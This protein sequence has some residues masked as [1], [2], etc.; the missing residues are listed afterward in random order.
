MHTVDGDASG[1][2]ANYSGASAH[3][4]STLRDETR[5]TYYH[6]VDKALS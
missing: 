1:F 4:R 5:D 3:R 2:S 6:G